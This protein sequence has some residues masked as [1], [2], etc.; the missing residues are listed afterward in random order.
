MPVSPGGRYR[1]TAWGKYETQPAPDARLF[2][3]DVRFK[4]WDYEPNYRRL[5]TTN[6]DDNGWLT[7]RTTFTVP[8]TQKTATV[9]FKSAGH[10]IA[11]NGLRLEKI[12]DGPDIKPGIVMEDFSSS[13]VNENRWAES[14]AGRSGFLPAVKSGSLVFDDRPM[15]TLVSLSNF[16][17][18]LSSTGDRRDRAPYQRRNYK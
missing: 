3:T 8:P 10:P 12:K 5:G 2:T 16:D 14:P 7:L 6:P 15:A 1:L 11:L 4:G 9:S 13:Y 18:L 17:E